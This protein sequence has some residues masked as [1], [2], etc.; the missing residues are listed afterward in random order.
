[1]L[2]IKLVKE[3]VP[4]LETSDVLAVGKCLL[5]ESQTRF[6]KI[7]EGGMAWFWGSILL[8]SHIS[9]YPEFLSLKI[10]YM[11]NDGVAGVI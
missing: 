11:E 5:F 8:R 2:E 3:N 4:L 6:L 10:N 7:C 9:F 1:M